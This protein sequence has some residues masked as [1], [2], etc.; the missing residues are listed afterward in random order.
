[1]KKLDQ[2][3][4][5]L[6]ELESSDEKTVSLELTQPEMPFKIGQAYFIQTVTLYY[7][8]KIS[9]IVG[10]FLIL[11]ECAW[12]ADTGRFMDA[13][14]KG[15]FNEVEPMPN[16]IILNSDSIIVATPIDFKLPKDQK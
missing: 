10:K 6:T 13:V 15:T 11:D 1:M 14:K 12:I 16:S 9:D 7:T 2:I 5:L 8:A 4:K 3:K